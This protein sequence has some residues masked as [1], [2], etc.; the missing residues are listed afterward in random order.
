MGTLTLS[1]VL[2]RPISGDVVP[3]AR[4]TFDAIA[5]GN[6]VL[7][8]VSSACKTASDGGYSVDL[9]YGSYAIQVSWAGQTQQ[10]GSVSIDD[11]TPIGSLNDLL[12]QELAESQLTPEIVLEFR[13]LEQEMHEGLAQ[14]E[15]LNDQAS[16]SAASA[17]SSATAAAKSETNSA[18]S[19]D[20][21]AA[22]ATAADT[23]AK[24]IEGDADAAADSAVAAATS[25]TNAAN[26]EIAAAAS[27]KATSTSETNAAASESASAAS[28]AAAQVSESNAA[29]SET[30]SGASASAAK[31]S[32]TNAKASQ[33][34]ATTSETNAK[35]ARDAA[36]EYA[37]EAKDAAS[38]VTSP[39]T[40]QGQWAIQT[41]YPRTPDIASVWQI[42][43]GGVDPVNPDIIWDPGDML[44][45]LATAGTWCRLLGQQVVAGEPVPLKIDADIILNVGSGLQIVTSGT[46]AVDVARLDTDNNLVLGADT[47]PGVC[48]KTAEPTNLFVLVSDG[49]GGY[50]KSRIYTEEFPPPLVDPGV[51]TV[52]GEAG[53]VEI[54]LSSLGAGTSA[55]LDATTSTTDNTVGHVLKVGDFGISQAIS[56]PDGVDLAEFFKTAKG[57][58][59]RCGSPTGF[60]NAPSW[61][62]AW[63]DVTLVA[64][65]DNYRTLSAID[66]LGHSALAVIANGAFSGWIKPYSETQKP[67]AADIGAVPQYSNVL[68]VDLNTLNGT[69]P[70]RYYQS[71]NVNAT[72]AY[73]YPVST[74]GSLDVILNGVG[75]GDPADDQNRG[76]TQ[77]YRPYNNSVLYRR[78]YSVS[79]GVWSWSGWAEEYST[80]NPP[81]ATDLSAYMASSTANGKFVTGARLGANVSAHWEGEDVIAPAGC[82]LTGGYFNGGDEYPY[83]AYLQYCINGTWINATGGVGSEQLVY[84]NH[85]QA[86]P[87]GTISLLTNLRPYLREANHLPG[88]AGV[89]HYI[90]DNGYD[91]FETAPKLAGAVFIAVAPDSG[92][93]VQI[94]D[95]S[96]PDTDVFSLYPNGVTV[97]GLDSLPAGCT[98]D[99]TWKFDAESRTV[100]QDA[101]LAP[102]LTLTKNTQLRTQYAATAALNIAILQASI[103]RDRMKPGDSDALISW[104]NYLCNLRDMTDADLQQSPAP[105]P[106]QPVTIL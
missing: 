24:S 35:N 91:W 6:V 5:T 72:A 69:K 16:G 34:A 33:A 95:S 29:A 45:Y 10:Y 50:T 32:E 49:N 87:D 101:D 43:D 57:A 71:M 59:Y 105:F 36:E 15:G 88:L 42:T 63:F 23:S 27:A 93:I 9:E 2:K 81:P 90:D 66:S 44:V 79:A 8:G 94:A 1:G 41:G 21:A 39:L 86:V 60:T 30:A 40:D 54:T 11:T 3:N 97:A 75:S 61:F 104:D 83:Y 106:E 92:V 25:E 20:A 38:K 76:C 70:G 77:E 28:A 89:Q 14:M 64:H 84:A 85:Y 68:T 7:K 46:T 52:N 19:E 82:V 48:I 99:G 26:S 56:V 17:A 96:L 13:Q 22:S 18:T 62:N 103:A 67:T 12:M 55:T 4:I 102:A 58:F 51:T 65:Q 31:T 47:L 53:D 78:T 80:V 73:H 74:A 37:Q 100:S 98:I